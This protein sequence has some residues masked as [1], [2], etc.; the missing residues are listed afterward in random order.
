MIVRKNLDWKII[1]KVGWKR[2]VLLAALSSVVYVAYTYLNTTHLAI[3]TVPASILGVAIAFLI[4]FRVN[5]AYE[6]WWEARKIWGA[7][8][9]DSRSFGRQVLTLIG[10]GFRGDMDTAAIQAIQRQLI[11]GQIGFV[12]ALRAHLRRQDI[13]LEIKPMV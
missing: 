7:L 4:G 3:S 12:H 10:P 6:R 13:L 1:L 11:Y 8:V 5:S 2:M 9:N